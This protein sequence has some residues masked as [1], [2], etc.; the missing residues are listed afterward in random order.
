MTKRKQYILDRGFQFRTTFS[1]LAVVGIVS[2]IILS[3]I[4]ASVMFNNSKIENIYQIEDNIFNIMQTTALS[5]EKISAKQELTDKLYK[6]HNANL[7]NINKIASYNRY[8]LI[9]LI[10]FIVIQIVVLYGVIIR[11]THRISGPIYVISNYI[12]EILNGNDPKTRPLRNKDELK[13]FYRLFCEL[14][15]YIKKIKK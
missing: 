2:I 11:M 10:V 8:L 6:R 1:I 12:K 13:G 14:F 7:L 9:G 3:M 15:E 5:E 4:S